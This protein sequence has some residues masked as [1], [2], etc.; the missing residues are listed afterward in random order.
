V[1]DL[2]RTLSP[3]IRGRFKYQDILFCS[4]MQLCKV[5]NLIFQMIQYI[6][7]IIAIEK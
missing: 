3:V 1:G 2:L 5:F 4:L 6:I 7:V